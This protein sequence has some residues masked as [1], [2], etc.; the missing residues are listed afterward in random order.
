MVSQNLAQKDQTFS[1]EERWKRND[2]LA[3]K[4]FGG[5]HSG[6]FPEYFKESLLQKPELTESSGI[7]KHIIII[8]ILSPAPTQF[9]REKKNQRTKTISQWHHTRHLGTLYIK[10]NKGTTPPHLQNKDI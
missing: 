10:N 1:V 7:Q 5:K 8:G 3:S 9:K 2:W 4:E 6:E